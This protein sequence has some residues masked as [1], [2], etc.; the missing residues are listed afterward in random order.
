M[1]FP[2]AHNGLKKVLTAEILSVVSGFLLLLTGT[3]TAVA[4][5]LAEKSAVTDD[6]EA[7]LALISLGLLI[8][9]SAV[10][11]L[12]IILKIV[13]L[14]KAGNDEAVFRNALI[15]A[16]VSL[17]LSVFEMTLN[18][19]SRQSVAR[20]F[21]TAISVCDIFVVI[22]VIQGIQNLSEKLDNEK[23]VKAGQVLMILIAVAYGF[24]ALTMLFPV[25]FWN[26]TDFLSKVTSSC[27]IMS[28]L[29]SMV[30]GILY[31]VYLIRAIRMLKKN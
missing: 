21:T 2:N 23:M 13:G 24:K 27:E 11:I 8:A 14:K 18:A 3:F 4:A 17:A 15:A 25:F 12:S 7:V 20:I 30:G 29:A 16:L 26:E 19:L 6:T 28:A 1:T 9:F 22:F 5:A 31:V 10:G